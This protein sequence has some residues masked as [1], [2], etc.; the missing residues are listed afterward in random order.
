MTT[1]LRDGH[2]VWSGGRDSEGHR[3]YKITHQVV[4]AYEDGPAN[5]MQTAG[6]PLPGA[7]W[8]F[9]D[10]IDIWAFCQPDM[11][12][13]PSS[14]QPD[15]HP[16]KFWDVT[17]TFSTK[18]PSAQRQRCNEQQ[19]ED[20]LLE[21]PKIS[22]SFVRRTEEATHDRFGA[23]IL[24]SSWEMIRG[25]QVEFD[26]SNPQVVIS[27]NV[28]DLQM[29]L[30]AQ[31]AGRS[32]HAG[33]LWGLGRRMWKLSEV[34]W[35][36][37]Y[38]GTCYKYYNRKL[39]F[40]GNYDTWDRD[41]LDIGTK[42]LH[43]HYDPTT[44]EW[45]LDNINGSSPDPTDPSHFDRH[46]DKRGENAQVVLDGSGRPYT[47]AGLSKA[48]VSG[49]VYDGGSGYVVDDILTVTGGTFTSPAK[50]RVK[51]IGVGFTP[52]AVAQVTLMEAGSY[53][54]RPSNPVSTTGGAGT[55]T[56]NL[57]W[58][59][60]GGR[61]GIVHVEKYIDADYLQLGIPLVL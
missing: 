13:K 41:L 53:T 16:V 42:A 21:P 50:F 37:R 26:T 6:L 60:F 9:D 39:T 59:A 15:N 35:E 61:V 8:L 52:S 32:V 24:T 20:P 10:D 48:P 34:T 33:P 45:T 44:G 22:G 31:L 30:L 29:D 49:S 17:Q 11:E 18:G 51:K 7:M 4:C 3:T 23:P 12:L 57:Y 1:T 47:S 25:Q 5:V 56:L 27:Q 36:E 28:P 19:I 55:C 14:G 54:V 38:Y 58:R 40:D 43:G 46:K 2:R